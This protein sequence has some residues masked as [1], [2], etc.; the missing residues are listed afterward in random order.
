MTLIGHYIVENP[1]GWVPWGLTDEEQRARL[2]R[3]VDGPEAMARALHG[4]VGHAKDFASFDHLAGAAVWFPDPSTGQA[5]G[6]SAD[7]V[8]PHDGMTAAQHLEERARP[9]R[10]RGLQVLDYG[11]SLSEPEAGPMVVEIEVS[12]ARWSRRVMSH[13]HVTVFPP[14]FS[15]AV[16]IRASTPFPPLF[17]ALIDSCHEIVA[18]LAVFE[19]PG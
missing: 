13:V 6:F 10:A 12:A 9:P 18:G 8:V 19:E 3:L 14:G 2:E 7:R 17:D 1:H 4:Y 5:C 16:Y 15:E 11:A